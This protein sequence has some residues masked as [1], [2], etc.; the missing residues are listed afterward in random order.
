MIT[1]SVRSAIVGSP[2]CKTGLKAAEDA[3]KELKPF[4]VEMDNADLKR[5]TEGIEPTMNPFMPQFD[6]DNL[7]C[8]STG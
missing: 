5:L 3:V 8:I 2:L 1:R 7:Y 4:R 6:D